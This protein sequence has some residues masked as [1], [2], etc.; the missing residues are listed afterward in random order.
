[1]SDRR[2]IYIIFICMMF[3]LVA[4]I[5]LLDMHMGDMD[6]NDMLRHRVEFYQGMFND[7]SDNPDV[8]GDGLSNYEELWIYFSNP[9]DENDPYLQ[10]GGRNIS[11]YFT[12]MQRWGIKNNISSWDDFSRFVY[13]DRC[14]NWTNCNGDIIYAPYLWNESVME[15]FGMICRSYN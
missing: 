5:I 9:F 4:N 10:Y 3:S 13:S 1:M 14:Y 2:F 8:D 6:D 7:V 12:P 15:N 11:I